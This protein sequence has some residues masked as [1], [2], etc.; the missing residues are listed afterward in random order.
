MCSSK[1]LLQNRHGLSY[2][3][4]AWELPITEQDVYPLDERKRE[5]G[6]KGGRE[7]ARKR[8]KRK[9]TPRL[10]LDPHDDSISQLTD[11]YLR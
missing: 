4:S 3:P 1:T 9:E 8:Q 11:H 2:V 10:V 6:R 7:K 5:R